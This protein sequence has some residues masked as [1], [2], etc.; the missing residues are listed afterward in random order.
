MS[1]LKCRS[2]SSKSC[3]D[4]IFADRMVD[5]ISSLRDC[6]VVKPI[7]HDVGDTT[8]V[9]IFCWLWLLI[10]SNVCG[11]DSYQEA[12]TQGLRYQ[13]QADSTQ[14]LV[15]AHV[16]AL[17]TA[18]E[19]KRNSIKNAIRDDDA[20]YV[21]LQKKA[22]EW[23]D[24]AVT[25]E[26][27]SVSAAVN[28]TDT[29]T[30]T[31]DLITITDE[32]AISEKMILP[33]NKESEFAILYKSPYSAANPIPVDEPL[34]DGVVYKIQLGA[35]SK[36][37]PTNTFKGLTP[38]SGE[39]LDNGVTKYY[40]GLFRRFI[41]ADEALRKVHEYGFKN[42]YIVAFYNHKTI[43]PERAKQLEK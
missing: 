29:M 13:M 12:V 24:K 35:F 42:A 26:K 25:F 37:L 39:K 10:N 33:K 23:F 40:V 20:L 5:Q 8:V 1:M 4:D 18:P 27:I 7:R 17:T 22:N 14:R 19:S 21:A 2:I 43:Q 32:K 16:L 30:K 28:D 34:A 41:D 15:E 9:Y 31:S 6:F 36:P 3:S 11:Q 38:L